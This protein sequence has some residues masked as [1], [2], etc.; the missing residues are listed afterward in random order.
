MKYFFIIIFIAIFLYIGFFFSKKYRQRQQFFN[1]IILLCHKFDVEIN[2][3]RERI[4]NIFE[5]LDEKIKSQLFGIDKNYIA[6]LSEQNALDK[7]SL[8]H[9]INFLKEDEKDLIFV[10]FKTLGRSDID[11]QSKEIRTFSSR[12]DEIFKS[13]QQ[14][15]KKY[16]TFSIK[17]AIIASI[18]ILILFI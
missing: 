14:E 17:L 11:S 16:G 4:K 8:F 13:A 9:N 2:F 12:F 18:F 7:H 10:F 1:A 15:N 6:Y 3:S 5:S